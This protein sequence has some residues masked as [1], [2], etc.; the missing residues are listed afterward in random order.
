MQ[1]FTTA[2]LKGHRDIE[3]QIYDC[4]IILMAAVTRL[5]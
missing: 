4:R 1:N 2:S 5:P 3:E